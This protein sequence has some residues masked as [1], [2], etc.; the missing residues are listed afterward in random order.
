[1]DQFNRKPKDLDHYDDFAWLVNGLSSLWEKW[2]TMEGTKT[3]K[4]GGF[5]TALAKPGLRIVG[6][7]TA[8]KFKGI[9][10]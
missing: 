5:Y 10:F 6:L 9:S 1:M 2:I 3:F 4:T 8:V 7:N